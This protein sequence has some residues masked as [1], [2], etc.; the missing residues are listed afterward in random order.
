MAAGSLLGY[1][2]I[3]SLA[4]LV[5]IPLSVSVFRAIG[6]YKDSGPYVKGMAAHALGTL[7]FIALLSAS[8]LLASVVI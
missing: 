6:S 1:L 3:Y 7:V 4:V 8:Y 2:P 5:T